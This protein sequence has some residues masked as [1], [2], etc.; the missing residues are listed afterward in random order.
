MKIFYSFL[1]ALCCVGLISITLFA[2]NATTPR[3]IPQLTTDDVEGRPMPA[4]ANAT[5]ANK[6][7]AAT[8]VPPVKTGARAMLI[9]AWKNMSTLNSGR[10]QIVYRTANSEKQSSYKFTGDD[11]AHMVSDDEEIII[12]GS[13][14]YMK[15]KENGWRLAAEEEV[16]KKAI[17]NF[18]NLARN[19]NDIPENVQLSGEEML[20]QTAMLK[21]QMTDQKN[22]AATMWVGKADGLVY[23]IESL[24]PES[25]IQMTMTIS[26]HDANI[27]IQSPLQ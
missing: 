15:S 3:K 26:D 7:G 8:P 4:P 2:Q 21:F 18:K 14:A 13:A 23:K 10:I 9:A 11:R 25:K 19:F 6:D 16:P 22:N 24:Q 20:G 12:I 5:T 27:S 1:H 17:L